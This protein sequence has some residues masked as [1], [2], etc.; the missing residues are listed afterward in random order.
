MSEPLFSIIIPTYNRSNLLQRAVRSALAQEMND[1][2]VIVVDDGSLTPLTLPNS[3]KIRLVRLSKNRG[4]SAARNAGVDHARGQWITFLDDD[5]ELLPKMTRIALGALQQTN[6]PKPVALLSGLEV[7]NEE[8]KVIQKMVP[9]TLLKGSYFF[10]EKVDKKYSF[11]SK[12]TLVVDKKTYEAVGGF[13]ETFRSRIHT[14][15]F[16]RLNPVCSL[17]GIM[18]VTYRLRSHT[19]PRISRDS[20]LRIKSFNQL[21]QKH[22]LIFRTHPKT[23][24]MFLLDHVRVSYER[25]CRWHAVRV[26]LQTLRLNPLS[27]LIQLARFLKRKL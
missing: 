4:P 6:L 23:Y 22:Q 25:G 19:G 26:F 9:P 21:I 16:L 8:G 3:P 7:V 11:I 20:E 17:L 14:E 1:L 13:D 27:A 15:F 12:Q 18:N 10:L 24:S 5:D 2:E